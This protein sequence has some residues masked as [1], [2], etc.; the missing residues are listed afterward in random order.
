MVLFT[1]YYLLLFSS[2]S[3]AQRFFVSFCWFRVLFVCKEDFTKKGAVEGSS[4]P[5]DRTVV[6]HSKPRSSAS[7]AASAVFVL[8]ASAC[9][10]L[11]A[12]AALEWNQ[13]G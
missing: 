8:T 7:P 6:D 3:A 13:Y 5:S 4:E 11:A 2:F 1:F 9:A 10:V 12:A